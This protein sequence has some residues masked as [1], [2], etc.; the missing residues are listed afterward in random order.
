MKIASAVDSESQAW[1]AEGPALDEQ[2]PAVWAFQ[3]IMTGGPNFS[4]HVAS[5]P[6]VK[7][8][9]IE[10]YWGPFAAGLAAETL[11]AVLVGRGSLVQTDP[12]TDDVLAPL[13]PTTVG[14]TSGKLV[15]MVRGPGPAGEGV[16]SDDYM[17]EVDSFRRHSELWH[18]KGQFGGLQSAHGVEVDSLRSTFRRLVDQWLS[19][20]MMLSSLTALALDKSYQRIIGLGLPALPLLL[21]ELRDRPHQWFW[22]LASIAGEDPAAGTTDF[23]TA[24]QLWLDWGRRRNLIK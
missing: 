9:V 4:N 3:L 15:W 1:A 6:S 5:P 18:G 8:F 22:A 19:E 7:A 16:V 12:V 21:E 14:A 2:P 17:A 13:V 24:R 20:T 23:D 10:K 11:A